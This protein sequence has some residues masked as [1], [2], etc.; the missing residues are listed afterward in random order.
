MP[1]RGGWHAPGTALCSTLAM[2]VTPDA[3]KPAPMITFAPVYAGS[4]GASAAPPP[5][6]ERCCGTRPPAHVRLSS[7]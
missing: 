7:A 5:R 2:V 3:T 1:P 4:P 6:S